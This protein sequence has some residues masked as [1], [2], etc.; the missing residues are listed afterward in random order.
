[1]T[2]CTSPSIHCP[3]PVVFVLPLIPEVVLE[4]AEGGLATVGRLK[5]YLK[6]GSVASPE[7]GVA[8]WFSSSFGMFRKKTEKFTAREFLEKYSRFLSDT[9]LRNI[10]LVEI[11][12]T[13][14]YHDRKQENPDDLDAAVRPAYEYLDRHRADSNK[15]VLSAVGKTNMGLQNNLELHVETQFLRTHGFGKPSIEIDIV[16]IPSAFVRQDKETEQQYETRQIGRA[17]V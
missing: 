10:L 14:V 11:D 3:P 17:H 6:G 12:Y 5:V 1:M 7:E 13:M 9:S 15:I 2:S 4:K 16:G 8:G